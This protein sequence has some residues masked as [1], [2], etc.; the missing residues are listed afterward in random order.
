MIIQLQKKNCPQ[1]PGCIFRFA[2][3]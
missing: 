2:Y 3:S 1:E